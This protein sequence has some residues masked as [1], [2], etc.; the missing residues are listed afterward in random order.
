[1]MVTSRMLSS[2]ALN[3]RALAGG[4]RFLAVAPHVLPLRWAVAATRSSRA[5]VSSRRTLRDPFGASRPPF[6]WGGQRLFSDAASSGSAQQEEAS[7]EELEAARKQVGEAKERLTE[8]KAKLEEAKQDVKRQA[9]RHTQEL[10]NSRKYAVSSL[11][12]ELLQVVD[13]LERAKKAGTVEEGEELP[14]EELDQLKAVQQKVVAVEESLRETLEEFGITKVN[15]LGETF[16][17]TKHEAMFAMPVPGKEPNIVV[18]VVQP[19]YMIYDR[20]L[21]AAQVGCSK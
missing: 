16:D 8:L 13:N 11:A 17:P 15:P 6:A 21:R 2:A 10:E 9:K 7:E 18:H 19:G 5:P 4:A 20:V 12:K 14:K 1:M 3:A